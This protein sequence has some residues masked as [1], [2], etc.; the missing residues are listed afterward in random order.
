MNETKTN[1]PTP[2]VSRRTFLYSL[3]AMALAAC[4]GEADSAASLIRS[5][6]GGT[7]SARALTHAATGEAEIVTSGAFVHPGLLHTRGDFDRMALKVSTQTPP[8]IDGWNVLIANGHASLSW[9]P[10][11]QVEVDRGGSGPQNY[12]VRRWLR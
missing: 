9:S 3:G 8:W 6:A 12:P 10:R 7:A 4:G 1:D 2:D 5:A 11:P